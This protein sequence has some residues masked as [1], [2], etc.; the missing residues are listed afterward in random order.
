MIQTP[1]N[2][3]Y[4]DKNNLNEL[5]SDE[6]K[7]ALQ[8]NLLKEKLRAKES[9][10]NVVE[11][12]NYDILL[13]YVQRF[14][15]NNHVPIGLGLLSAYIEQYGYSSKIIHILSSNITKA[16]Q[17]EL[18]TKKTRIIGFYCSSDNEVLVENAIRHIKQ[19][20][21]A[22]IFVGGPQTVAY[23]ENFLR[24]TSC[25]I[26]VEGEGEE[27]L[28]ELM[29]YF[30][31][32]EGNLEEIKN[33]KYIDEDN[34][35]HEND[36]REPIKDLDML[37]FPKL[38]YDDSHQNNKGVYLIT[39][40]GCPYRCTFCYEGANAKVVRFRSV[41]N[42]I[43]E[44]NYILKEHPDV[45]RLTIIDDTF[46][47]DFNRLL[48]FCS[49]MKKIRKQRHIEWFCEGHVNRLY[50]NP[51]IISEMV[52]AGL[53][54][55]QIGIES[56]SQVVLNAYNKNTTP[57]M[58]CEVVKM[59]KEAKLNRLI[60]NIIIGGPNETLE[61]IEESISMA[62][63]VIH[64]GCGMVEVNSLFLWPFPKTPISKCPEKYGIKVLEGKMEK[65]IL[66][67]SNPVVE[68]EK[69]TQEE[70]INAKKRFDGIINEE[71][72]KAC[73]E[74]DKTTLLKLSRK[75]TNGGNEFDGYV[76]ETCISNYEYLI[77]YSIMS[78]FKNYSFD[79]VIKFDDLY[80]IRTFELLEYVNERLRY[81]DI[82][83]DSIQTQILEYSTGTKT[84]SQIAQKIDVDKDQVIE[85]CK[86]LEKKGFVYYSYF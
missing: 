72:K 46:T 2:E 32:N 12:V 55:M 6:L 64:L 18:S 59:C 20:H 15:S 7:Q 60:G 4:K 58:I 23:D 33:I 65:S 71:Y 31:K 11:K 86:E 8:M 24:E 54:S 85:V 38:K 83:F 41:K 43:E 81:K 29:D 56:G 44:I 22:I 50:K 39:G 76:W 28:K 73:L 57:E 13:A 25:D 34:Q 69:L 53:V 16:F 61:T 14:N 3:I 42:V 40:R 51:E 78:S 67:F 36:I 26:I 21:D 74:L 75:L 37:P 84:I 9:R 45:E 68:T 52:E 5:V 19:T 70:L 48:E 35:Y 47:L 30:V 27:A 1:S 66:T 10:N 49:E 79:D 80:T 82:E 77:R 17:E 62:Q 63:K